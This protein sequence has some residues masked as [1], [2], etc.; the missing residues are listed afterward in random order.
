MFLKTHKT[1]S[2]TVLNMLYRFGELRE[3]RFAL[4]MGYLLGYPHLFNAHQVEKVMPEDTFY[5]SILRNPLTLV[6]SS[7][8]YFKDMCPAFRKADSLGDFANDPSS[9]YDPGL[10]NSH[11]ARNL[12]WFDFGLDHNGNFSEELARSGE[13]LIRKTFKLILLTEYF[14][15]SMVLL[16]HALCW[17][18][19]AV[20]SFT[21]NAGHYEAPRSTR[22]GHSGRS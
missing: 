21:L 4:P 6:V 1:A 10:C 5:F 20:V 18:L 8:A 19:D 2:S 7:F 11:F 15:R 9:F 22:V 14:D 16:R 17:P 12:L 3:L 13:A